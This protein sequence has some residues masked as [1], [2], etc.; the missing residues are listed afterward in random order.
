MTDQ[1]RSDADA[2]LCIQVY[3]VAFHAQ[4]VLRRIT[5]RP[6]VLAVAMACAPPAAYANTWHLP[7]QPSWSALP[8]QYGEAAN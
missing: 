7:S 3:E 6:D 8:Q 1:L 4:G 2:S 5:S